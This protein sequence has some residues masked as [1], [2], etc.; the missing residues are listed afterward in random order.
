[1]A[2]ITRSQVI[3]APVD[4]VFDVIVNGANFAAWNPTVRSFP[5][6]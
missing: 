2:L 6:A 5:A 3:N 4:E 1:M